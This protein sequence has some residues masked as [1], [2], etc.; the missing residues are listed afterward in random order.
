MAFSSWQY[1]FTTFWPETISSMNPFTR[2]RFRCRSTKYF[3][4]S[5][6]RLVV[7]LYIRKAIRAATMASGTLMTTMLTKV[8]V[9]VTSDRNRLG[10]EFPTTCRSVSTSFV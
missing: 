4:D 8:A 6:P 7:T 3:R 2:P 10:T 1:T 5:F 9:M